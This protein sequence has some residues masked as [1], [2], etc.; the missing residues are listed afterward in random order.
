[1][2]IL[3]SFGKYLILLMLSMVQSFNYINHIPF[4]L[5][6][7]YKLNNM[8]FS[9][10]IYLTLSLVIYEIAKHCFKSI[11][12]KMMRL[13]GIHEYLSF[14]VGF[15][16]LIQIGFSVLFYYYKFLMIFVLYRIFLSL[17]NNL[18]S[19]I[20]FPLSLLY[21]NKKIRARLESFSF[22]QKFFNFLIFFLSAFIL[23]DLNSFSYFCFLLSIINI[24]CLIVYLITFVC[25]S[26]RKERQYF[27]QISEKNHIKKMNNLSI[28]KEQNNK[29]SQVNN[30]NDGKKM[31]NNKNNVNTENFGDNTNL[32]IITG[33]IKNKL[34]LK[35][36][37]NRNNNNENNEGSINFCKNLNELANN[38]VI[39][40][41]FNDNSLK[42][43]LY[44]KNNSNINNS[45][46]INK[47]ESSSDVALGQFYMN[48]NNNKNNSKFESNYNISYQ[49]PNSFQTSNNQNN[50]NN[51]ISNNIN[52]NINIDKNILKNKTINNNITH[53]K[54]KK[55]HFSMNSFVYLILI[56][57]AFKFIH[58][59]SIFLLLIKFYESKQS[60]KEEKPNNNYKIYFIN[61]P[62]NEIMIVFALYYFIHMILFLINKFLAIII[63]KGGCCMKYF[64]LY[65]LQIIYFVSLIAFLFLFLNKIYSVRKNI[66]LI[67]AFELIISEISMILLIY[68]NKLAVNKGINQLLLKETK[69]IGILVGAILFILFNSFRGILLYIIKMTINF[70]DYYFLYT[71]FSIFFIILLI[72]G[73]LF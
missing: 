42:N 5:L 64:I 72:V 29:I 50:Q 69:S 61:S 18:S 58:Y 34:F 6:Y 4:L 37:N 35:N 40:N 70:F 57:S 59:F 15:L 3:S 2:G 63:I 67:F 36:K 27:P 20:T 38:K 25:N 68:Y 30:N 21:D 65:F 43:R 10:Y 51:H 19:F 12:I 45:E 39:K 13:I 24:I 9:L 71:T 16:I 52:I 33:E 49:K 1:M 41:N 22:Y 53:K 54:K 62:L 7:F 32:E 31:N 11:S 44:Q 28:I 73:F 46:I 23:T 48:N 17:F 66:I 47:I 60:L 26:N 55:I 8:K 14:S 56:H